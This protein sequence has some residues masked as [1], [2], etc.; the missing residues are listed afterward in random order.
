MEE[1]ENYCKYCKKYFIMNKK[2]FANHVR[3][4]KCNPKYNEIFEN[5]VLKLKETAQKKSTVK[6]RKVCCEICNT[7]YTIDVSDYI[8]ETGKYKK[9]AQINVLKCYLQKI[10]I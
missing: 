5:T 6:S 7:E 4:C 8:F 3:W 9:H 10:Q 2:V 1:V